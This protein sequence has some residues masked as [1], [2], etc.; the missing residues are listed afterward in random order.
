MFSGLPA[1]ES[2]ESLHI[3]SPTKLIF[4]LSSSIFPY[5]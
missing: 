2:R 1:E 4:R 5:L 3:D